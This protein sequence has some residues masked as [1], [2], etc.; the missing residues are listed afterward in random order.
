MATVKHYFEP[1]PENDADGLKIQE[2]IDGISGWAEIEA[3]TTEIGTFPDYISKFVTNNATTVDYWFRIAWTVGGVEQNWSDPLQVGDLAPKYT[4]PDLVRDTTR[5]A[6]VQAASTAILQDLIVQAYYMVQS[7]CGPFDETDPGFVEIA[8]L[9]MRL[10]I[11]F[12]F[13][14]Q[15][16]ANL[17]ALAGV[18]REKVGSYMVQRSEKAVE[19]F[20][21]A[22]GEVPENVRLLMCPFGIAGET[23][24]EIITTSVFPETPWYDAD[25]VDL[26]KKLVVTTAD[27]DRNMIDSDGVGTKFGNFPSV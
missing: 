14:T 15:D 19:M 22:Q 23:A 13:V 8:P 9:A 16:P 21:D 10:Y 7:S 25:E 2:S 20:T 18:I 5:H 24:V 17:S 6:S 12:L 4:T 27:P 3:L 1:Y 26:D 11:E